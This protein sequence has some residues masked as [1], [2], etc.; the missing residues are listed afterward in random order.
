MQMRP[1]VLPIF[2]HDHLTKS[3]R[4]YSDR[5][6]CVRVSVCVLSPERVPA[7]QMIRG[8]GLREQ[9][10]NESNT[11]RAHTHARKHILHSLHTHIEIRGYETHTH[12]YGFVWCYS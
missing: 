9:R 11:M 12:D 7:Q 5:G 6:V 10:M 8:I 3:V 2:H 1:T 4:E